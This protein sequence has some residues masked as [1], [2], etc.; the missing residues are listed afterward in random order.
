[1][2]RT[3]NNGCSVPTDTATT[4]C[5]KQVSETSWHHGRGI[6]KCIRAR[7]LGR[8]SLKVIWKMSKILYT[9]NLHNMDSKHS[10]NNETSLQ[11]LMWMVT[12]HWTVLDSEVPGIVDNWER[13]N[14]S[15]PMKSSLIAYPTPSGQPLLHLHTN[16]I[17]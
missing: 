16:N 10:L 15:F 2:Y 3:S 12:Y 8:P 14:Q 1:M 7:V 4:E 17:K 5:L 9:L 6:Q 11:M 13:V